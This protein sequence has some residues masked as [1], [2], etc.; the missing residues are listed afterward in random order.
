LVEQVKGA[1]LPGYGLVNSVYYVNSATCIS[2]VNLNEPISIRGTITE[3]RA[4]ELLRVSSGDRLLFWPVG[5]RDYWR[6]NDR[7]KAGKPK[8]KDW[9]AHIL[10]GTIIPH[11]TPGFPRWSLASELD[12]MIQQRKAEVSAG[13]SAN[14]SQRGRPSTC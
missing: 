14:G 12:V 3:R 13:K 1:I 8:S 2:P 10:N 7:T 6:D 5:A 11:E 4:H 9:A